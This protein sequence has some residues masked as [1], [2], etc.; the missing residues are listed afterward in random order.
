M[1]VPL[2]AQTETLAVVN[3]SDQL[4]NNTVVHACHLYYEITYRAE[5]GGALMT[6][7]MPTLRY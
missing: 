1:K 3:D 5:S 6:F 7:P 4:A 2:L